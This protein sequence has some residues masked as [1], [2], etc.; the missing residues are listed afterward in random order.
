M[1]LILMRSKKIVKWFDHFFR[2][3]L[4]LSNINTGNGEEDVR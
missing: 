1:Q 4:I 2:F 3:F